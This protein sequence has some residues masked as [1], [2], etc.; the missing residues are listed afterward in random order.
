M[1]PWHPRSFSFSL[2]TL[3][4]VAVLPVFAARSNWDLQL[5]QIGAV[6]MVRELAQR[7]AVLGWGV[8]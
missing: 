4:L 2:A 8:N 1:M 3:F 7:Q 6:F 5:A